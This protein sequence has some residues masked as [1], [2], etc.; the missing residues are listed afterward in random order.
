MRWKKLPMIKDTHRTLRFRLYGEDEV[1]FSENKLHFLRPVDMT[2]PDSGTG[3]MHDEFNTLQFSTDFFTYV[4]SDVKQMAYGED[5]STSG[6]GN[7]LSAYFDLPGDYS[8]DND[9][10]DSSLMHSLPGCSFSVPLGGVTERSMTAN[11][12]WHDIEVSTLL[13]H[14]EFDYTNTATHNDFPRP[15]LVVSLWRSYP[16][17]GLYSPGTT[18]EVQSGATVGNGS[19]QHW[20]LV[21]ADMGYDSQSFSKPPTLYSALPGKTGS[22]QHNTYR[23]QVPTVDHS[24]N[25]RANLSCQYMLGV[26]VVNTT[27]SSQTFFPDFSSIAWPSGEFNPGFYENARVSMTADVSVTYTPCE[28]S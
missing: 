10:L 15:R 24:S 13:S 6:T 5:T 17:V 9:N 2:T 21:K 22:I 7:F 28:D 25:D 3:Q 14:E 4:N 11:I 27:T 18:Q 1:G 19:T 12:G 26:W 8:L 23:C 20:R 16:G